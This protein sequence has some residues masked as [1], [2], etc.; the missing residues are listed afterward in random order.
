MRNSLAQTV[1]RVWKNG[2]RTMN[3]NALNFRINHASLL[4]WFAP[5]KLWLS[6]LIIINTFKKAEPRFRASDNFHEVNDGLGGSK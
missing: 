2:S 4:A 1:W 3:P 5:L 6:D